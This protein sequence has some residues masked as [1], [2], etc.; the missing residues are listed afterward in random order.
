[1]KKLIWLIVIIVIVIAAVMASRGD[2]AEPGDAMMAKPITV[3]LAAVGNSGETGTA[4]ISDENGKLKVSVTLSG[5][6]TGS[7]Q[8][9][10]IHMGACPNPGTVKINLPNVEN[11]TSE[12]VS[13]TMTMEDVATAL[14]TGPLALNVHLSADAIGT[15]VACGDIAAP[16]MTP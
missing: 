7:S 3:A 13:E 16:A 6:P 8:P 2:D 1:M 15:Y 11:G 9:A 5:Q 14:G 4:V 12:L 10:H